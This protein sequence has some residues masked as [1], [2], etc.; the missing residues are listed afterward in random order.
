MPAADRRRPARALKAGPGAAAS[1]GRRLLAPLLA[2]AALALVLARPAAAQE[3]VILVLEARGA[4]TPAMGDYFARA[5]DEAA[6]RDVEAVLIVLDTPGGGLDATNRIVQLFRNAKVPVIV[7]V[8]PPGAQAASAGSILVA[9]AHAAGMAPETVIG[10]ASP[11]GGE[12][13]DVGETMFRKL[14]EDMKATMRNLTARRGEEAVRLAEAMID[15]ARAVTGQEALEAGFIDALAADA[16]SLLAQL[17]GRT[18]VVSGAEV[19]LHTAAAGQEPFATSAIEALLHALSNPL[20]LG[21]LLT[22]GVQAILIEISNPGGWIAGF[23]G[24][25]CLSLALYGIGT[26]PANWFGLALLLIAFALFVLEVKAAGTGGLAVAASLTFLAGLLVLFNSPG[27]PEFARISIGGA[28]GVSLFTAV[29]FVF[30]A[31]KALRAQQARPLTGS[32]GMIGQ[33]GPVRAPF[34]PLPAGAGY[35]GHALVMG[36]L[37]RAVS[38]APVQVGDQVVVTG[39][40]G[41]TVRVRPL[42]EAAV[43]SPPA[44]G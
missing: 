22:I 23:I 15:D 20:V 43:A 41:F 1:V 24:V 30:L 9:A 2:C 39:V 32:E 8:Y 35:A 37:W 42:H 44:E 6:A 25:M 33:V 21:F 17:D 31:G 40:D 34:Q 18:V 11:V 5:L 27:T 26:L 16:E 7:Y 10:A 12:G 28:I 4:V 14:T 36:E 19:T 29:F 13:E 3:N 38:D